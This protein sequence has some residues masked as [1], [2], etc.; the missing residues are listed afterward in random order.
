[1]GRQAADLRWRSAADD[2]EL[3]QDLFEVGRR[4]VDVVLLGVAK[5]RP[6]VRGR[7]VYRD[8]IQWREPRQLGEQSKGGSHHHELQGR[9]ALFGAAARKRLIGLYGEL[10]HAALE[11]DIFD[12]PCNGS[13][14]HDPLIR[15]FG[16][17]LNSQALDLVH[18]LPKVY[19]AAA[20]N[21]RVAH[22]RSTTARM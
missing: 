7:I 8:P 10:S 6:D 1:M 19:A 12:D 5:G 15:S 9:G 14:R 4:V 3:D 20:G 21:P 2:V 18:L 13:R 11:V 16:A 22:L 17:H